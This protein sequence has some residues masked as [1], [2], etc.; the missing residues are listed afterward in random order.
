MTDSRSDEQTFD[1][2]VI[3]CSDFDAV[4][5]GRGERLPLGRVVELAFASG[6]LLL[7]ARGGSGK[8]TTLERLASHAPSA[9]AHALMLDALAWAS[10]YESGAACDPDSL[11]RMAKST[12][13][14]TTLEVSPEVG[15]DPILLLVDG[16]NEI[17]PLLGS[18]LLEL[19]DELAAAVPTVGIVVS[20]RLTRRGAAIGTWTLAS[21]TPV[22]GAQVA[23][24]LGD[25]AIDSEE[26]T[27]RVPYYLRLALKGEAGTRSDQHRNFLRDHGGL[28]LSD[29]PLLAAE[30]FRQY[31]AHGDRRLDLD[32]LQ[33]ALGPDSVRALVHAGTI[34]QVPTGR[35][36]HHLI[37]D[38]L[39]ATYFANHPDNWSSDGLDVLTFKSSSMDALAMVLEQAPKDAD[40]LVREVYNWNFYGAAYLIAED[41]HG[42]RLIGPETEIA[43]T[44]MLAERQFDRFA[45]TALRV[46]DALRLIDSQISRDMLQASSRDALLSVAREAVNALGAPSREVMAWLELYS[47]PDSELAVPSDLLVLAD[48]DPIMGWT[49]S[50]VL[51]RCSM[52][53]EVSD[54][55]RALL[56]TSDADVVRW[57]A[58][59]V[60]G[61]IPDDRTVEGLLRALD[62]DPAV[63]VRYGAIRSL[64]DIALGNPELRRTIFEAVAERVPTLR[65]E[66]QLTREVERVLVVDDAP[67]TWADDTA[68]LV[69][70]LWALSE[71]VEEQD[72]WRR[73]GSRVRERQ[74]AMA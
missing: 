8:T 6:R 47:R 62:D 23:E 43:V 66:P 48:P 71:S 63:W 64:V 14:S 28:D 21:L 19:L 69:E 9:S 24:L 12:N 51:R 5:E 30:A 68:V 39:A 60:A 74:V 67:S 1:Y 55:I 65:T 70:T 22:S 34:L 53:P 59:H 38:Y 15:S 25:D 10:A 31:Q 16:L 52:G 72:R 18:S 61:Q 58:A 2:Q 40:R 37:H 3:L 36:A 45:S 29:L 35:F 32:S 46:R 13:K 20:D 33:A 49:M 57:R 27:L 54:A 42:Q 41:R 50:N 26:S 44:T 17:S 56:V 4:L 7:Q 11:V 73:L